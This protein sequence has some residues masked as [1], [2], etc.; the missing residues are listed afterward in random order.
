MPGPD[1]LH[2]TAPL[3]RGDPGEPLE[4]PQGSLHL[5][6]CLMDPST[7]CLFSPAV[8]GSLTIF[9]VQYVYERKTHDILLTT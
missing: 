1:D 6:D 7:C 8:F 2:P 3:P 5:T 4:G 9:P